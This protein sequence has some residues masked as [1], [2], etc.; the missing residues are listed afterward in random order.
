[1]PVL[2]GFEA[3]RK[4][5]QASPKSRVVILCSYADEQLLREPKSVGGICD[6]PK[7][8]AEQELVEAVKAAARGETC[9][10]L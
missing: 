1:M 5:R 6:I 10:L 8:D 7:S 4:I 9:V 3:A 2:N